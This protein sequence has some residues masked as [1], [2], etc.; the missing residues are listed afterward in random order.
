MTDDPPIDIPPT[1][2]LT[3]WSSISGSDK[4]NVATKSR[5]QNE[6]RTNN[7]HVGGVAVT[8]IMKDNA[9][10]I[11]WSIA[12]QTVMA[13]HRIRHELHLGKY[14]TLYMDNL[15]ERLGLSDN[16]VDSTYRLISDG[17]GLARHWFGE[18]SPADMN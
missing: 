5:I 3:E 6:E 11:P 4:P 13:A 14:D 1:A 15:I 18:N 12:D 10:K 17:T 7:L 2:P 8:D 9:I 16:C